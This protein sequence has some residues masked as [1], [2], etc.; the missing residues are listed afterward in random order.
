MEKPKIYLLRRFQ[1]KPKKAYL[2]LV[3]VNIL[4]ELITFMDES[5]FFE[6]CYTCK[7][8][9]KF[10][11]DKFVRFNVQIT[12]ILYDEGLLVKPLLERKFTE[13]LKRLL[14]PAVFSE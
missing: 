1:E 6:F 14:Y 11:S 10:F 7:K 5:D 12:Q 3:G 9:I 2:L 13:N 8:F 4:R